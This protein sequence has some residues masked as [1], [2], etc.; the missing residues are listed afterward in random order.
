MDKTTNR[1]MVSVAI[2]VSILLV[3]IDT[4]I[5]TTASLSWCLPWRL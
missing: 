5:V 1:K 3:A 4:T 2:M